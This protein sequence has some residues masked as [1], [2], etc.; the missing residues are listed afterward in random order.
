MPLLPVTLEA[1]TL[2][3]TCWKATLTALPVVVL[4][5]RLNHRVAV[6]FGCDDDPQALKSTAISASAITRGNHDRLPTGV[7]SECLITVCDRYEKWS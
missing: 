5:T 6:A 1:S 7:V 3:A 2:R 4:Q